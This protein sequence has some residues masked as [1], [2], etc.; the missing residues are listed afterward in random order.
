MGADGREASTPVTL[1]VR[2]G[3][4]RQLFWSTAT[5]KPSVPAVGVAFHC[6]GEVVKAGKR[7]IFTR[8]ELFA[9]TETGDRKL[10]AT[11]E[12]ILMPA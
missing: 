9:E 5:K 2:I 7:Q 3:W 8:A 12:T 4:R 11:G 10:V 6:R 1:H